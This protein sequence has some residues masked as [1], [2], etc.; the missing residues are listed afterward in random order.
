MRRLVLSALAALMVLGFASVVPATAGNAL[1]S[2]RQHL[3]GAEN[4]DPRTGAVR[5]DRARM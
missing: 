1:V 3:F 2:A 5:G 4:V